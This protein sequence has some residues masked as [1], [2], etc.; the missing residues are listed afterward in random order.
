MPEFKSTKQAIKYIKE[1]GR[2]LPIHSCLVENNIYYN[3]LG[4]FLIMRTMPGGKFA[5]GLYLV[6][7]FLLGVKNTFYNVNLY[8]SEIRDL[9]EKMGNNPLENMDVHEF[10]NW[11]Y[12][13]V[14]YAEEYGFLPHKDFEVSQYLLDPEMITDAI[15]DLEFGYKGMPFYIQGSDDSQAKVNRIIK[16]LEKTAGKGNFNYTIVKP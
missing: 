14:D 2:S 13:A 6:D 5:I 10:H 11:I 12:G 7:T 15:D 1:K 16:Q 9:K 4:T 3:G 8:E